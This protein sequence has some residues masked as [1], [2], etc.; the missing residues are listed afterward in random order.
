M[1]LGYMVIKYRCSSNNESLNIRQNMTGKP[2]RTIACI[3]TFI[4]LHLYGCTLFSNSTFDGGK[5]TETNPYQISTIEQL[6]AIDDPD[7]LDKH[8][9]QTGDIDASASAEFQNGSG[10]RR[11]GIQ[12]SPFTGSFNGNR[13]M[14]SDLT[15]HFNKIDKH[16]GLFGYVKNGQ[17]KN[18]TI[19]NSNQLVQNKSPKKTAFL[20][21]QYKDSLLMKSIDRSDAGGIG[22]LVGL[23]DGGIIS[24]CSF[25]GIVGGSINQAPS[26]LV[27]GNTG[28]I[29]NSFF[30]GSVGGGGGIGLVGWNTGKIMNSY[31]TGNFSG[32]TAYG[33]VGFNYGDIIRSH[34]DAH[35]SAS[36]FAAGLVGTNEGIIDESY[37]VGI[38]NGNKKAAGLV[39]FNNGKIKNSYSMASIELNSVAGFDNIETTGLVI[40]NQI[41]GV[42]KYS[43]TTGLVS[44]PGGE[45]TNRAIAIKNDGIID[46]VYWDTDSTGQ[47]EGVANGSPDGATGLSTAQMTG[48]A[49]EQNMP[50]FDWVNIWRTTEDGYPVLRWEER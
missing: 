43:Y 12:G 20:Q 1:D 4:T 2:K 39:L 42:I 3:I 27:G 35:V 34:A 31:A 9:I 38:V 10:F 50:E 46:A 6:Q 8:F 23:N 16:N 11:I 37:S 18:V 26:G 25:I 30:E 40:E 15:I 17:I 44:I 28:I 36:N 47:S 7:Y 32:M 41:N 5:G 33:L 29:E 19:N 14:I 49:A 22:G 48:P 13:Y 45:G 21:D 24:N